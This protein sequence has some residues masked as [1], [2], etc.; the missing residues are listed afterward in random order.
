LPIVA[1]PHLVK[2]NGESARL[3]RI[4]RIRVSQIVRSYRLCGSSVEETCI[5]YPHLTPAEVHSAM[6]YYHDHRAEIDTE[7]EAEDRETEEALHRH[8]PSPWV[9]RMRAEGKIAD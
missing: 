4:P 8:T 2:T 1:Y 5:Q 6:A 7:I 9:Q 3:E